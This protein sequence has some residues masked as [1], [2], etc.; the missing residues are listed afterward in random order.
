MNQE[1][2]MVPVWFFIGVLL[3]IYGVILLIAGIQEISRPPA[4]VLAR[5][6]AVF[7]GGIILILI[8]GFYTIKF[9][10]KSAKRK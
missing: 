8:G 3:L 9:W 5:Y 6:H 10:P 4:V 2:S 1:H 7:W